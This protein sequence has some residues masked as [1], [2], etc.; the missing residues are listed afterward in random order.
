MA[1]FAPDG[2]HVAFT[3][4][5]SGDSEIWRT[6]VSGADGVQLTAMSANPGW[7]RWSPNGEQ[8]AFHALAGG[9][10]DIF[11]VPAEGGKPVNLTSNPAT[12]TFPTYSRD[13]RWIYFASSRSGRSMIWKI[14]A[15]GGPAVQIV[16]GTMAIESP[17]GTHLFYTE[18]AG[19]NSPARLWR[20]PLAGGAAVRIAEG[21]NSTGIRR[22]GGG[23]YYLERLADEARVQYIDLASG[24]GRSSLANLGTRRR[25]LERIARWPH[26]SLQPGGSRRSTT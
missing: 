10:G 16:A 2:L 18:G 20:I 3:S 5:R 4:T 14:P 21:V 1:H 17:D 19:T 6:D 24:N 9:T 26:D 25:R 13:G 7:P 8:I 12:D 22:V 23:V 11:V 15:A